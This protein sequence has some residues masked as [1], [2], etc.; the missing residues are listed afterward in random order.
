MY[1]L[2]IILSS[3]STLAVLGLG[4]LLGL[5]H[6]TEADHLA[7]VIA[8]VSE[9]RS[10]WSS[11]VVG[12]L[13]GVGHTIS[14]FIA[15]I[16]VLILNFQISE[17]TERWLEFGVG[18]MLTLL[19]L[20]VVRKL[21]NGGELHLHTHDHGSGTHAHPHLHE[22][23]DLGHTMTHRR[24]SKSPKAVLI[25]MVHGLAGSAALMLLLIPTIESKAVGLIYIVI[26]GAGSVGGMM[27]MSFIVGLPFH[28]TASRFDRFNR[29]LQ[30]GAGCLSVAL[31]L[32]IMYEKGFAEGLFA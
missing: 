8:M 25:G 4:F 21:L 19:G 13:W 11:A 12:G 29:I 32:W 26:F 27:L 30:L 18:I 31:G 17:V 6:A 15:G 7:A 3:T 20:N 24:S 28:F 22:H 1:E 9:R 16:V 14:L 23:A 10:L 2:I 5:K